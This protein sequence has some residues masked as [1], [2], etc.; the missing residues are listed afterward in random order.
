MGGRRL[1]SDSV[2][3]QRALSFI[4]L[5][6]NCIGNTP[7]V[8]GNKDVWGRAYAPSC[9]NSSVEFLRELSS[10]ISCIDHV[11]QFKATVVTLWRWAE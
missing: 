7:T 5:H 1:E 11:L 9:D 6:A 2:Q 4:I 8:D 10:P 3:L